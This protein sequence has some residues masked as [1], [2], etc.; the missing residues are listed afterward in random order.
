LRESFTNI[1]PVSASTPVGETSPQP[2]A[3]RGD[4]FGQE[5]RDSFSICETSFST[6][7]SAIFGKYACRREG[8]HSVSSLRLSAATNHA[9]RKTHSV[10]RSIPSLADF[11]DCRH[12]L[13]P[14]TLSHISQ[15]GLLQSLPSLASGLSL[16]A[17]QARQAKEPGPVN[18]NP[19]PVNSRSVHGR[20]ARRRRRIMSRARAARSKV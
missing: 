20:P 8:A 5:G 17:R 14:L 16:C 1:G 4:S 7:E 13:R 10:L 19:G 2:R 9:R 3:V 18:C 11:L 6:S 12:G 15:L